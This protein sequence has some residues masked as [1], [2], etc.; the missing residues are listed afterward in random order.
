MFRS[1]INRSEIVVINEL[2]YLLSG[3]PHIVAISHPNSGVMKLGMTHGFCITCG[4]FP[5]PRPCQDSPTN[6]VAS[7]ADAADPTAEQLATLM[8]ATR[9]EP[10][11]VPWDGS[12]VD[13]FQ[14]EELD[15]EPP[16]GGMKMGS[17]QLD[18]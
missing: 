12:D 17:F 14:G 15:V 10:S 9:S 1:T 2:S 8:A 5:R 13:G 3:G 4:R 18:G 16:G 7:Q 11:R 6:C